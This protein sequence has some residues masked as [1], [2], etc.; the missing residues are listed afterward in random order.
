MGAVLCC[1]SV[2]CPELQVQHMRVRTAGQPT[3]EAP[4]CFQCQT[5]LEVPSVYL[6]LDKV[7]AP[8]TED[9]VGF[10]KN[11]DRLSERAATATRLGLKYD[12]ALSLLHQVVEEMAGVKLN[13]LERWARETILPLAES[14]GVTE[15]T[16]DAA[17]YRAHGLGIKAGLGVRLFDQLAP[18]YAAS[19]RH[20]PPEDLK[21][22]HGAGPDPKVKDA[23][24]TMVMVV[25]NPV[26]PLSGDS[27]P[28]AGVAREGAH[29]TAATPAESALGDGERPG[30]G[31]KAGDPLWQT[32]QLAQGY[33]SAWEYVK[34]PFGWLTFRPRVFIQRWQSDPDLLQKPPWQK[35]VL[36]AGFLS[37]IIGVVATLVTTLAWAKPIETWRRYQNQ[38]PVLTEIKCRR[39]EFNAG[40]PITLRA[41][42]DDDQ[43]EREMKFPW[44]VEPSGGVSGVEDKPE[45]ELDTSKLMDSTHVVELRI[46]LTVS[47]KYG[48]KSGELVKTIKVVPP[49]VSNQQPVVRGFTVNPSV[50]PSGEK[51]LLSLSVRDPE[52]QPLDYDWNKNNVNGS[53][54]E[55]G[56]GE[57][58]ILDTTGMNPTASSEVEVEV[59]VI[60]S[61]TVTPAIE[62]TA[63]IIVKPAAATV[64]RPDP[65]PLTKPTPVTARIKLLK[66]QASK[67]TIN[68]LGERIR[69]SALAADPSDDN[70][71]YKWTTDAGRIDPQYGENV[72]LHT[73]GIDPVT[74]TIKVTMTVFNMKGENFSHHIYINIELPAPP[75]S[76]SPEPPPRP[77]PVQ[78]SIPKPEK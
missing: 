4:K 34:K 13:V 19:P 47:D 10:V 65:Q 49:K 20:T 9:L 59:R 53:I 44:K 69:F 42:Y 38:T 68:S 23:S 14:G 28:G 46:T 60:I 45:I 51:V 48:E 72:V 74:K 24:A 58:A 52:N 11:P 26:P 15:L 16:R 12:E 57:Q 62:K 43:K 77:T 7:G 61:D 29:E 5:T 41:I 70:L 6:W 2:G 66:C 75:V 21:G 30:R 27:K 37:G 33:I 32:F 8:T 18:A 67:D 54:T 31:I 22:D 64:A 39:T 35:W 1:P 40:E 3:A 55:V 17:L 71:T 63:K 73:D 50:V 56:D 76:P 25:T 78:E 36:L